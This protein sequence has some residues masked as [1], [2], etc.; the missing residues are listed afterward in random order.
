MCSWLSCS[1]IGVAITAGAMQLTSTPF[2]AQSL[3][4]DFG[5]ADHRDLL[6]E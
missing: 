1:R 4:I 6:T 2:V 5:Q 3:P